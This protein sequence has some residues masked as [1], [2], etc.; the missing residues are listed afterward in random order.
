MLA[1]NARIVWNSMGTNKMNASYVIQ[2]INSY[3]IQDS[4]KKP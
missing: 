3:V 2:Q 4:I 1:G